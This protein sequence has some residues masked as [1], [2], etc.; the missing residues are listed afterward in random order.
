[1][2]VVASVHP[3]LLSNISLDA[4]SMRTILA[5]VSKAANNCRFQGCVSDID[6]EMR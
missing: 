2:F 3:Y 4:S 5:A 1:M 6:R